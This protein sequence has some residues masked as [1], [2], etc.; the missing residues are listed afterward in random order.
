MDHWCLW[1]II[2]LLPHG[3]TQGGRNANGREILV[4]TFILGSIVFSGFIN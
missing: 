1:G 3:I 2:M 4:S